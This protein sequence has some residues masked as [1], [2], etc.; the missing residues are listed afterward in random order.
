MTSWKYPALLAVALLLALVLI[1]G[2][3]AAATEQEMN[4]ENVYGI[5]SGPTSPTTFTF[6]QQVTLTHIGTYHYHD[7]NKVVPLGTLGLRD[8][9]GKMYGPWKTTGL[10]GQG[11][12]KDAFWDATPNVIIPAGTYTLVDSDPK[13]WSY[14]KQ[15][16]YQGFASVKYIPV[17]GSGGSSG[18]AS[19][20]S[21]GPHFAWPTA[22]AFASAVA[23]SALV[24]AFGFGGALFG[25]IVGGFTFIPPRGFQYPDRFGG[26]PT[27]Y[28]P[29]YSAGWGENSDGS[30]SGSGESDGEGSDGSGEA[31]P[32]SGS[33]G[34]EGGADNAGTS[35]GE[36]TGA[37]SGVAGPAP[38]SGTGTIYG[39][40]SKENPYRDYANPNAPPWA[41]PFGDG[42]VESPYADTQQ[43]VNDPGAEGGEDGEGG[44]GAGDG[45]SDDGVSSTG[46]GS[47]D[48]SGYGSGP[49]TGSGGGTPVPAGQSGGAEGPGSEGPAD[50]GT[51]GAGAGTAPGPSGSQ[52][53]PDPSGPRPDAPPVAPQSGADGGS[54]VSPVAGQ[55][56]PAA[57]PATKDWIDTRTVYPGN[58]SLTA[59]GTGVKVAGLAGEIPVDW[60]TGA[61]QN[62]V[63]NTIFHTDLPVYDHQIA[64]ENIETSLNATDSSV[65]NQFTKSQWDRLDDT[66]RL[67]AIQTVGRD[68]ATELGEDGV[69]IQLGTA[70]KDAYYD[71]NL[72]S[73]PLHPTRGTVVINPG[74]AYWTNPGDAIKMVGHEIKHQQQWNPLNP[75][76]DTEARNAATV[77]VQNYHDYSVDPTKYAGQYVENDSNSFGQAVREVIR[78]DALNNEEKKLFSFLDE[79]KGPEPAAPKL[80][81][82]DIK[83]DPDGFLNY[84]KENPDQ[85]AKFIEIITYNKT[86]GHR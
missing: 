54:Q 18:G 77:N 58:W 29:G 3:C 70:P 64:A 67:A 59:D 49:G 74:S 44:P 19:G 1:P 17:G 15:S 20:G 27:P 69:D 39:D 14:N 52:E 4:N 7:K 31:D 82:E 13:T 55:Q 81:I 8:A 75:M 2:I 16:N 34:G 40:G 32:G 46:T 73:D 30:G 57:D 86:H 51:T 11:G 43:P 56:G 76:E 41:A 85:K 42:S 37:G 50:G 28:D 65:V 72:H 22:E 36:G 45:S 62:P 10:E 35:T 78:N 84:L 21:S 61:S 60:V 83:K 26:G 63:E 53:G 5:L 6:S 48:G 80:T 33:S 68:I 12:V 66:Q 9:S 71:F 47:G 79:L 23:T 24:G 38:S 25:A